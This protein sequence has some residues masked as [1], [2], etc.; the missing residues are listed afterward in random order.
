MSGLWGRLVGT[1]LGEL[2]DLGDVAEHLFREAN[3]RGACWIDVAREHL[4][5]DGR[6]G[7]LV[8]AEAKQ[9]V[10]GSFLRPDTERNARCEDAPL[11]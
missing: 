8:A 6:D 9:N 2:C 3:E 7:D 1:D 10:D 11:G 4:A 5:T